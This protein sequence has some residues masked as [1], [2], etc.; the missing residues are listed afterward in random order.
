MLNADFKV[1]GTRFVILYRNRAYKIARFRLFRNFFQLIRHLCSGQVKQRL[2]RF[3]PVPGKAV[4]R[5][6]FGG[7]LANR[8]EWYIARKYASEEMAGVIGLHLFGLV[9]VQERGSPVPEDSTFIDHSLWSMMLEKK[10]GNV[11]EALKQ[12]AVFDGKVRLVD[13]GRGDLPPDQFL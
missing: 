9:L 8:E 4:L 1:G 2:A 7:V 12:F 11:A 3:D 13:M 6:V 10:Q 5:Y